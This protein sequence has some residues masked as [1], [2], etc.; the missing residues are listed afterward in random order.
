MV[1]RKQGCGARRDGGRRQGRRES[2]APRLFLRRARPPR[3]LQSESPRAFARRRGR[4][5]GTAAGQTA[6]PSAGPAPVWRVSPS[7]QTRPPSGQT[8]RCRGV[9]PRRPGPHGLPGPVGGSRPS[10]EVR[11]KPA[12]DPAATSNGQPFHF[13]FS[14][15]FR[16]PGAR[17]SLTTRRPRPSLLVTCPLVTSLLATCPASHFP[18]WS[19]P[20]H[21]LPPGSVA[22]TS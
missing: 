15:A 5:G 4:E 19:R 14:T 6:R 21:P 8:G 9:L 2:A 20:G 13:Q 22:R 1:L 3:R 12:C 16:R 18:H 7:G 17:L 10:L 11:A